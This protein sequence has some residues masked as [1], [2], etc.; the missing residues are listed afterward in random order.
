MNIAFS[1]MHGTGNDFVVLDLIHQ[2]IV[3]T[4]ALVKLL[5]DRH[6]GIGCDQ[7]LLVEPPQ[8]PDNDFHYRIFN[9]DGSEVEHCGNGAR[10]FARF[11]LDKK[12]THKRRIQVG[13]MKGDL[14]LTISNRGLVTV[15]M[16]IPSFEP[17]TIPFITD[18]PT[19]DEYTLNVDDTT[20]TLGAL[21]IGN[22]HAIVTVNNRF[23]ADV[24][25]LGPALVTHNAFPQHVNASFM[26]IINRQRI[27]LRVFERGAGETLSCGTAAC[28]AVIH[29]INR[30]VLDNTVT[31]QLPGGELQVE[32]SGNHQNVML[33]GPATLVFD[34][35]ITV[36]DALTSKA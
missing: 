16:G 8:K 18:Q 23:A 33:T 9:A 31:V 3:I 20:L 1:K 13:T 12:L 25:Q 2:P 11:V 6:R 15:A 34:G 36:A 26:E 35:H 32:W 7:V 19:A 14:T 10:C 17:E 22:P 24:D 21:A 30:K 5:A 4:P 29:G 27:A 28:A